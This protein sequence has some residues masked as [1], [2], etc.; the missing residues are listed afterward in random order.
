MHS[1]ARFLFVLTQNW[2]SEFLNDNPLPADG[3][4]KARLN[5]FQSLCTV[6]MVLR[7]LF[8]MSSLA[9][10]SLPFVFSGRAVVNLVRS[11]CTSLLP[12]ILALLVSPY[13]TARPFILPGFV[14]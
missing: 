1:C 5:R 11:N 6:E 4:D 14:P 7:T 10:L 8:F 13:H 9:T 2:H 3:N 12:G